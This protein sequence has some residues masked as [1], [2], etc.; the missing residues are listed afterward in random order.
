MVNKLDSKLKYGIQTNCMTC[1]S[2]ATASG[3]LPY[4]TD[5]YVN[6]KDTIFKNQVQLDFAW[7]IQAAIINDTVSTKKAKK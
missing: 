5:Q 1:H 2:F 6:M 4:S 7:S 3:V